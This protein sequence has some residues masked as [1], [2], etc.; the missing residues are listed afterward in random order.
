[1]KRRV[2]LCL[3][4]LPS[5]SSAPVASSPERDASNVGGAGESPAGSANVDSPPGP[6]LAQ[7]ERGAPLKTGR[8][9]VQ[10]LP[11]GPVSWNVIRTSEPGLGANQCAPRTGECGASPR[12]SGLCRRPSARVVQREPAG[13]YPASHW[14][15]AGFRSVT[16]RAHHFEPLNAKQL[17]RPSPFPPVLDFGR[18]WV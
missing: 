16:G 10:L 11:R 12:H 17:Q 2:C 1:M 4:V 18:R 13:L 7:P 9:Q 14:I 8:L 6:A 5:Y 3:L 15:S